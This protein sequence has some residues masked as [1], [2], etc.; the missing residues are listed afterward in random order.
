MKSSRYT[1]ATGT[2]NPIFLVVMQRHCNAPRPNCSSHH[3]TRIDSLQLLFVT[4][5]IKISYATQVFNYVSHRMGFQSLA[6]AV[7]LNENYKSLILVIMKAAGV[8]VESSP[9]EKRMIAEPPSFTWPERKPPLRIRVKRR[10]YQWEQMVLGELLALTLPA[11]DF[12]RR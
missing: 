8:L 2:P 6:P 3:T 5:F 10:I 12:R 7:T 4:F 1:A 9:P 11:T